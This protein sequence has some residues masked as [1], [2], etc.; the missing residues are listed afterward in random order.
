M[1]GGDTDGRVQKEK[2]GRERSK[3]ATQLQSVSQPSTIMRDGEDIRPETRCR[4][5]AAIME[6]VIYF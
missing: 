4:Q 2:K 6:S 5:N 3:S 1:G